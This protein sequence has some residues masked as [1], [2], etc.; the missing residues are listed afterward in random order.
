MAGRELLTRLHKA[1]G[2]IPSTTKSR[3]GGS[4]LLPQYQGVEAVGSEPQGCP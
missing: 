3:C 1:S 4:G 2:S